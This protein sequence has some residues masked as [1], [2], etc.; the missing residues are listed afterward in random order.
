M[1]TYLL[2]VAALMLLQSLAGCGDGQPSKPDVDDGSPQNVTID[3]K[4]ALDKLEVD[5][6]DLIDLSN[7]IKSDAN[8]PLKLDSVVPLSDYN[9]CSV[10]DINGLTY[11]VETDVSQVCRFEY[12]VVP[13]DDD[14]KGKGWG[15]SEVVVADGEAERLPPIV[16]T[17]IQGTS[18]GVTLH[19]PIGTS[20]NPDSLS[21]YGTTYSDD[22]TSTTN[23]GEV[24]AISSNSFTYTA[25]VDAYG[26]V[27]I[28]YETTVSDSGAIYS[29]AVYVGISLDANSAPI[30]DI[31]VEL[32]E[33]PPLVDTSSFEIDISEYITDPDYPYYPKCSESESDDSAA[34]KDKLQLIDVYTHGGGWAAI[35]PFSTILE[36]T[37]SDI[38]QHKIAYVVSDH[39]GGYAIGTISFLIDEYSS[40]HDEDN[41]GEDGVGVTF[42]PTYTF[43]SLSTIQGIYSGVFYEGGT[44]GFSGIYP[45]FDRELA[46]AYCQ[47]QGLQLPSTE[48]LTAMHRNVF[49]G[50]SVWESESLDGVRYSWPVGMPYMTSNGAYSLDKN[51]GYSPSD[52]EK[53]FVSCARKELAP[54]DFAFVSP[55]YG[56]EWDKPITI[57]AEYTM[58]DEDCEDGEECDVIG[59]IVYPKD[60]YNLKAEVISTIPEGYELS[61]DVSI[62]NNVISAAAVGEDVR[63]AIL[64]V[65][66]LGA[67]GVVG[68]GITGTTQ[69]LVG[70]NECPNDA[71]VDDTQVLGCIPVVRTDP[72]GIMPGFSDEGSFNPETGEY[73]KQSIFFTAPLSD[74]ILE[75]IG[76]NSALEAKDIPVPA[77]VLHSQTTPNYSYLG[78]PNGTNKPG[79]WNMSQAFFMHGWGTLDV[80]EQAYHQTLC[81]IYNTNQ[82]AGRSNWSPWVL[83]EKAPTRGKR[84]QWKEYSDDEGNNV[85]SLAERLNDWMKSNTGLSENDVGIG[86]VI[87][88]GKNKYFG[89]LNQYGGD[90]N[91]ETLRGDGKPG[92]NGGY[93]N[94]AD[95]WQFLACVSGDPLSIKWL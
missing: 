47:T 30:A 35:K 93:G 82:I 27:R 65:Q 26:Q 24:T 59:I 19:L 48:M 90:N 89:Q 67:E 1:K 34:C 62:E 92:I 91:G 50:E 70:L 20:L 9:K 76:F 57:S 46:E 58:Y 14:F 36:Y 5:S 8:T 85:L 23:L 53:G 10:L 75:R 38:G 7:S 32:S 71:S 13:S 51:E 33:L 55:Y 80:N 18:G 15:V 28:Y 31:N 3:T 86:F 44:T 49:A 68:S 61:V 79:D 42:K 22:A 95:A 72:K 88:D 12:T 39:L 69:I 43:D 87:A 41:G 73:D 94:G 77:Y 25:P 78:E 64:E 11:S 60:Q 2:S 83:I 21:L 66:D 74:A 54:K 37:P 29:G 81:D 84:H 63:T 52:V 4:D 17:M 40:I 16:R 56:T 6:F 45:T